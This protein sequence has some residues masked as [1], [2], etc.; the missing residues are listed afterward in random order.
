MSLLRSMPFLTKIL[1]QIFQATG[2]NW[3]R[4]GNVRFAVVCKPDGSGGNAQ[5]RCQSVARQWSEAMQAGRRGSVRDFVAAGDVEIKV[6]GADNQT[7]DSEVPVRQI[8][9]QLVAKT[10]I[11][12]FLLGLSGPPP[13]G[14]RPSR[15]T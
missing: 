9:E 10:G 2:Q 5:E 11:P 13:S 4:M 7:L 15:P 1:L 12:P 6:I 14:C 8:L 3:E